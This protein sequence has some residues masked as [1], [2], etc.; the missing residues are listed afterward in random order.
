MIIQDLLMSMLG[1]LILLTF[2]TLKYGWKDEED[3]ND[4]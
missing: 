1:L 3:K 4:N 2:I